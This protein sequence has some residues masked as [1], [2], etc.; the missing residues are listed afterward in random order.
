[1]PDADDGAG[2]RVKGEV[3]ISTSFISNGDATELGKP[4]QAALDFPAV[5]VKALNGVGTAPGDARSEAAALPAA[6][7]MVAALSAWS[8]WGRQ[9]GR[10]GWPRMRSTASSVGADM[11]LSC[12]LAP[13]VVRPGGLP[14]SSTTRC[15]LVPALPRS[16]GWAR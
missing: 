7:A 13:L 14:L 1:L 6:P 10:P 5:S 16:V 12:R 2:E 3:D 8:L 4:S 11:R 9:R 15:R